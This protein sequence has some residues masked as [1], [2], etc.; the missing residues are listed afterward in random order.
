MM[1]VQLSTGC[2]FSLCSARPSSLVSADARPAVVPIGP[3]RFLVL[4]EAS[5]RPHQGNRC[6]SAS[7]RCGRSTERAEGLHSARRPKVCAP[8]GMDLWSEAAVPGARI[9][10]QLGVGQGIGRGRRRHTER[11]LQ[12]HLQQIDHLRQIEQSRQ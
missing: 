6:G 1:P 2:V 7:N 9:H 3:G 8:L 12:R 4:P 10:P 5:T 11:D